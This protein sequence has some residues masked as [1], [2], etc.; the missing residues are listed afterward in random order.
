[1]ARFYQTSQPQLLDYMSVLPR[2]LMISAIS[3]ADTQTTNIVNQSGL[4]KDRLL[5]TK[6]LEPDRTRVADKTSEYEKQIDELTQGITEDP[7]KWRSQMPKINDLG[8][9]L[10]QDFTTGEFGAIEKNYG[11]YQTY[12]TDQKK[13]LDDSKIMQS[14][15]DSSLSSGLGKWK[16]TNYDA[17]GN[18]S[19]L[20]LE[21]P[22]DYFD[23]NEFL[24]K[25]LKDMEAKGWKKTT[26]SNGKFI[27]EHEASGKTL[28][29]DEIIKAGYSSLMADPKA[30]EYYN[31]GGRL[32]YTGSLTDESGNGIPGFISTKDAKGNTIESLN[33][34]NPLAVALDAAGRKFMKSDTTDITT[35]KGANAFTL[36]SQKH[37]EDMAKQHDAQQ[38]EGLKMF[39]ERRRE[40]QD[41][42]RE[43][44]IRKEEAKAAENALRAE[45]G[46]P[47][48]PDEEPVTTNTSVSTSP[49]TSAPVP[50]T[51]QAPTPISVAMSTKRPKDY[52]DIGNRIATLE[53]LKE[54]TGDQ[55]VQ[56]RNLQMTKSKLVEQ[57]AKKLGITTKEFNERLKYDSYSWKDYALDN[58]GPAL[59][60]RAGLPEKERVAALG[61]EA[62]NIFAKEAAAIPDF[63]TGKTGF[64][65]V[66]PG[67]SIGKQTKDIIDLAVNNKQIA[68]TYDNSVDYSLGE[69]AVSMKNN[70]GPVRKL[71][72]GKGETL[73]LETLS[74]MTKTPIT[75]LYTVEAV[76]NDGGK[77]IARISIN[78]EKLPPGW[79]L[80]DPVSEK[81][82]TEF[83]IGI[84]NPSIGRQIADTF[85]PYGGEIAD[86]TSGDQIRSRISTEFRGLT[87]T[88]QSSAAI[89]YTVINQ[90]FVDKEMGVAR[91]EDGRVIVW[92]G[93]ESHAVPDIETAQMVMQ[94]YI[95]TQQNKKK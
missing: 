59:P 78:K 8:R 11:Q 35:N 46:L 27:M 26:T 12:I 6:Y 89:P 50:L 28:S 57:G 65:A 14:Q 77:T 30:M 54:R 53:H 3:N 95:R 48:L 29:Y 18:Y 22:V 61:Q 60:Y 75:D 56:L 92:I 25:Q 16:G 62:R 85:T 31:Q 38:F 67:S 5:Q 69:V 17:T 34:N 86:I 4:L 21:R 7:T 24:N 72:G 80:K 83:T 94:D 41:Q 10:N 79:I 58:L 19:Q 68:G 32:G 81:E 93:D 42:D 45:A 15:Y 91:Q 9:K 87:S 33:P 49:T 63:N 51:N 43:D 52:K 76:K 47:P 44:R 55:E 2:E 66:S 13:R 74:K 39:E 64:V 23:T 73:D 20:S 84:N 90:P 40:L 36:S 82:V 71:F 88:E 1:M 37:A 70:N